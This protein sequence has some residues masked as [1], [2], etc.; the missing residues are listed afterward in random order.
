MK[1]LEIYAIL[2]IIGIIWGVLVALV[3]IVLIILFSIDSRK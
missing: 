2:R 3:Y 1:W